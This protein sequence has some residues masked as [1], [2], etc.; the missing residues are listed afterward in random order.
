MVSRIVATELMSPTLI[1]DLLVTAIAFVGA[2]LWLKLIDYLAASG[3]LDPKLSRKIIHIGTGPLFVLCWPLFSADPIARYLAALIPITLTLRYLAIGCGWMQAPATVQA[4][5]RTGDPAEILRGPLYYGLTFIL[6][7]LVFWRS[8]PVGILAL[9]IL[10]GGDGLADIVGRRW[11]QHKLPFNRDKSWVGSAGMWAGSFVL[12]F[13]MLMLF[14][15]L[16]QF[17]MTLPWMETAVMVGAIAG[18]ATIVEA[19]P[20]QEIDNLT[21]VAASIALG[22]W[23]L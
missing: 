22:F 15:A 16:G 9:M 18:V 17:Q 10:C 19:L 6:C 23:L 7:T 11:G 13:G 1:Q 14:N 20:V 8:S 3:R 21:L 5:T 2:L 12:G 4:T